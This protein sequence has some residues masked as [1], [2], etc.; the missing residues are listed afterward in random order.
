LVKKDNVENLQYF[1]QKMERCPFVLWN[2][3]VQASL[4][5]DWCSKHSCTYKLAILV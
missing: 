3:H 2:L 1:L 4:L 5:L